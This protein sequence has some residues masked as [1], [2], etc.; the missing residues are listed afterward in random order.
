MAVTPCIP[1]NYEE[2]IPMKEYYFEF[3]G[4]KFAVGL[5]ARSGCEER[6][7]RPC[8]K[9]VLPDGRV[10]EVG[11]WRSRPTFQPMNLVLLNEKFD[12]SKDLA[13][14]ARSINADLARG[15]HKKCGP[16]FFVFTFSFPY[17]NTTALFSENSRTPPAIEK[18]YL[19]PMVTNAYRLHRVFPRRIPRARQ[20]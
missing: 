14:C 20:H 9:I 8:D 4:K 17:N 15:P 6:F 2:E 13:E 12:S 11:R 1:S 18:P 7:V 16:P 5:V 10:L 19:P 3:G